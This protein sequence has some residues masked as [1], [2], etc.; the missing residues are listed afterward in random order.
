MIIHWSEKWYLSRR[1]QNRFFIL[2]PKSIFRF[3]C[4]GMRKKFPFYEW[5][6]QSTRSAQNSFLSCIFCCL[7]EKRKERGQKIDRLMRQSRKWIADERRTLYY[8]AIIIVKGVR[9]PRPII[10]DPCLQNFGL[11]GRQAAPIWLSTVLL[12]SSSFH[13]LL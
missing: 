6:L 4:F 5:W 10:I 12:R 9:T 3:C 7:R 1:L 8:T 13:I 11:W 2:A